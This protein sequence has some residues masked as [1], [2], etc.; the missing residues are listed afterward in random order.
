MDEENSLV[1]DPESLGLVEEIDI[2]PRPPKPEVVKQMKE[3]VTRVSFFMVVLSSSC[4]IGN[5]LLSK[6]LQ[7]VWGVLNTQ[8]II[9]HLVLFRCQIATPGNIFTFNS[10]LS[11]LTGKDKYPTDEIFEAIFNFT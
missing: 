3:L 7:D 9:T 6:A 2:E 10:L 1:V 11:E 8:I 5:M 4:L